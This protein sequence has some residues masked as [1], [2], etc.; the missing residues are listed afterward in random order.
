MDKVLY[1]LS[2]LL[3]GVFIGT[4]SGYLTS[5]FINTAG[6]YYFISDVT[7]PGAVFGLALCIIYGCKIKSLDVYTI[8][9]AILIIMVGLISYCAAFFIA[10]YFF[11]HPLFGAFGIGFIAGGVG[12]TLMSLGLAAIT[13]AYSVKQ[14]LGSV[15]CGAILSALLIPLLIPLQPNDNYRGIYTFFIG[16]QAIM[17]LVTSIPL[18]EISKG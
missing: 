17:L 10:V 3:L 12:T 7:M 2:T 4:L 11:G 9:K 1:S 13:R 14:I 6:V 15:I 5:S 8:V 18:L 16:W